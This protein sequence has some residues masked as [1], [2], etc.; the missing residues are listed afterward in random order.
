[1]S[2]RHPVI[3]LIGGIGSGKSRVASVFAERGARIISGDEAGHEALRQP[4]IRERI[5]QRWGRGVLDEHGEISRRKLGAVVF[6]RADERQALEA[7]VFP[8]IER[9]LRDHIAG[10]TADPAVT[11][12]LLDAAIMLEAGWNK[13]C[14]AIVYVHAPRAIRLQRLAEQRGW[15]EKEV[16]S[17]EHAQ[18]SL[19][20]KVTRADFAV[21]NS[22]SLQQLTTQVDNLIRSWR[23]ANSM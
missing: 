17:R 20:D 11:L 6:A 14:D 5:V 4:D 16:E 2:S 1:V 8:W 3:G 9:Q 23:S 19:T 21:D 13:V 15:T 22:G 7:M 18:L 10:A 12:V